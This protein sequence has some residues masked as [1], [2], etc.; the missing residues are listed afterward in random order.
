MRWAE[1]VSVAGAALW[2]CLHEADTARAGIAAAE[3]QSWHALCLHVHTTRAASALWQRSC[4]AHEAI[5]R[6]EC[7]AREVMWLDCNKVV[8]EWAAREWAQ[9]QAAAEPTPRHSRTPSPPLREGLADTAAAEECCSWARCPHDSAICAA[10]SS[11]LPCTTP[12][13]STHEP[14]SAHAEQ[15][16][17][18]MA[19]ASCQTMDER[20]EHARCTVAYGLQHMWRRYARRRAR[21]AAAARV[22]QSRWR[23]AVV[24]LRLQRARSRWA[25]EADDEDEGVFVK[26]DE[27][28]WA[29][30]EGANGA[31]GGCC[32]R[33]TRW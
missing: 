31:E 13:E 12:N 18:T 29:G 26:V 10:A 28:S 24:R 9:A 16:E 3:Q 14:S 1:R 30:E 27:L 21:Y 7:A 8:T 4:A 20:H 5:E 33:R 17:P 23:G 22:I 25:A 32:C 19:N 11:S 15:A 2:D 6:A